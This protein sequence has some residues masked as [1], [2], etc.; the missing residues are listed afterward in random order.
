MGGNPHDAA[1]HGRGPADGGGLLVNLHRGA[2]DGRGQR[3]GEAGAATAE[4]DDVDF[5]VPRHGLPSLQLSSS[6]NCLAALMTASLPRITTSSRWEMRL[7]HVGGDGT[8]R[9]TPTARP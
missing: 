9:R 6:D 8:G 1:G 3:G 2:R 4:H 7:M 5:V